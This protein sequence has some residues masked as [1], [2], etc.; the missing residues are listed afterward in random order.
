M[1]YYKKLESILNGFILNIFMGSIVKTIK[2]AYPFVFLFVRGLG[3]FDALSH[4]R[5][6]T[7]M[8]CSILPPPPLVLSYRFKPPASSSDTLHFRP[9][10]LFLLKRSLL[11]K[12]IFFLKLA[13]DKFSYPSVLP[14]NV[15]I[16]KYL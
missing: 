6:Q 11:L 15:T 1:S 7:G 9:I 8:T 5:A 13:Y 16:S 4:S 14:R 2:N 12:E 10:W 3:I